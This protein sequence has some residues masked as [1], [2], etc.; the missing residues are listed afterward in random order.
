MRFR[1]PARILGL[2]LLGA[3]P[4]LTGAAP[5]PTVVLTPSLTVITRTASARTWPVTLIVTNR[6]P[7]QVALDTLT[8]IPAP[9][10]GASAF[11]PTGPAP[12][13]WSWAVG[14]NGRVS[15][16]TYHWRIRASRFPAAALYVGVVVTDPPPPGGSVHIAQQAMAVFVL[17]GP[18]TARPEAP[19]MTWFARWVHRAWQVTLSARNPGATS[20]RINGRL[21]FYDGSAW[22]GDHPGITWPLLLPGATATR[23]VTVPATAFPDRVRFQWYWGAAPQPQSLWFTLASAPPSGGRPGAPASGSGLGAWLYRHRNLARVGGVT[24]AAGGAIVFAV[25]WDRRVGWGSR[26]L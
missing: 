3:V 10:T 7:V 9:G 14:H 25:W 8:P 18:A 22:V 24:V 13:G 19:R 21:D 23:V 17:P 11:A 16:G 5:A 4:L 12:D 1:W 20:Y 15:A 6:T 2:A 26:R